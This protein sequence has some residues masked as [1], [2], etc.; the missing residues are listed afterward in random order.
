MQ[1]QSKRKD[2]KAK[3]ISLRWRIY[4]GD[5]SVW[6]DQDGPPE[7]APHDDV[8]VIVAAGPDRL[9]HGRDWYWFKNDVPWSGDLQGLLLQLKRDRDREIHGVK[10]GITIENRDFQEL[11]KRAV[12]DPD[13]PL[14]GMLV[15]T[16]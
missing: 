6:S 11:L 16:R 5:G 2:K 12:N 4:F 9:Q 8:Q 14:E 1:I 3:P 10:E 7:K 15:D 13:F